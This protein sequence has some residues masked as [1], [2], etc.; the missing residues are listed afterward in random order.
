MLGLKRPVTKEEIRAAYRRAVK[1]HHPDAGG[2]AEEFIRIE[3]AYR[4]AMA[5]TG[6]E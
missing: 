2:D 4:E 3:A 5:I 1:L 6:D